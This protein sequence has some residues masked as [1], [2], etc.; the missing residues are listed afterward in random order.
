MGSMLTQLDLIKTKLEGEK[1]GVEPDFSKTD[2]QLVDYL[3]KEAGENADECIAFINSVIVKLDKYEEGNKME[4]EIMQSNVQEGCPDKDAFAPDKG[5]DTTPASKTQGLLPRAPKASPPEG[6]A[7]ETTIMM[8]G[9]D[10]EG[11]KSMSMAQGG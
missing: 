3:I 7:M 8:A 5:G 1:V 11:A 6:A 9:G 2:V 4:K 10:K